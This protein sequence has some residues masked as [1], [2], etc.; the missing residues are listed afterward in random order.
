MFDVRY[1]IFDVKANKP[2]T[3]KIKKGQS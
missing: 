2:E 1:L 3:G